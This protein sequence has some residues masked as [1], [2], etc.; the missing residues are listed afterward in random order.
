VAIDGYTNYGDSLEYVDP[1]SNSPA[2][3]WGKNVPPRSKMATSTFQLM[4]VHRGSS[5][6]P[7]TGVGSDG[8]ME[9]TNG[10]A[11]CLCRPAHRV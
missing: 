6:N 11:V 3:S 10:C 8:D 5:T 9:A 1:A 4:A 7:M 2:L